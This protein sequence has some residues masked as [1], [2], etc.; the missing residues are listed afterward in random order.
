MAVLPGAVAPEG[1]GEE[2]EFAVVVNYGSHSLAQLRAACRAQGLPV[3]G[4]KA[5]LRVRLEAASSPLQ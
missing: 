3:G 5:A 2:G 4:T 1:T